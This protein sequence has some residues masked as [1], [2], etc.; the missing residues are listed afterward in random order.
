MAKSVVKSVG[1]ALPPMVVAAGEE[2][3]LRNQFLADV[4]GAVFGK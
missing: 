2:L 3:F 1:G 4:R